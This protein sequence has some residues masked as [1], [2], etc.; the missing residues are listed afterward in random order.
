MA[1]ARVTAA[2]AL[3]HIQDSLA[4]ESEEDFSSSDESGEDS[5][6][7]R[8]YFEK[9]ID[10]KED[11]CNRSRPGFKTYCWTDRIITVSLLEVQLATPALPWDQ[12]PPL[13]SFVLIM[14]FPRQCVT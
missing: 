13:R 10:P 2:E 3:L 9:W 8:L 4:L 11:F 5:E 14:G 7:E 1:L 6:E 12:G